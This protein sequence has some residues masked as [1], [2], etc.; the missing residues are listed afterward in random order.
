M[1]IE[2]YCLYRKAENCLHGHIH[3]YN[4]DTIEIVFITFYNIKLKF[5][6]N[7]NC[8]K[9]PKILFKILSH[10]LLMS[11]YSRIGTQHQIVCRRH[12]VLFSSILFSGQWNNTGG[13]NR[14][15]F[16]VFFFYKL[17]LRPLSRS[18]SI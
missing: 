11:S 3:I 15:G 1:T 4:V 13:Q 10:R 6:S 9:F 7:I 16:F 2:Q 8:G 5:N 14:S 17:L 12:I 18:L